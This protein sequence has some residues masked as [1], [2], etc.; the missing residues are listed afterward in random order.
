MS[1]YAHLKIRVSPAE[2]S[3]YDPDNMLP[4][5]AEYVNSIDGLECAGWWATK[6]LDKP[7]SSS[8]T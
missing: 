3:F 7:Q 4:L 6:D 5:V 8:S 2:S 1:Y